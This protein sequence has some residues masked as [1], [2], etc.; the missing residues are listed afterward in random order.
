MVSMLVGTQKAFGSDQFKSTTTTLRNRQT[1]SHLIR[2]PQDYESTAGALRFATWNSPARVY[3]G[4]PDHIRV[5]FIRVQPVRADLKGGNYAS[6]S[7]SG[8]TTP[9][10]TL[11]LFATNVVFC[12]LKVKI[13]KY[14]LRRAIKL[15]FCA[16]TLVADLHRTH[17]C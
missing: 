4:A 14:I 8:S 7:S 6:C 11:P 2:L 12:L 1:R 10:C 13:Y 3:S 17:T 9:W 16:I 5:S 15:H